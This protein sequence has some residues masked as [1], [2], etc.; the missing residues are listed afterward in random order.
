M[1]Y[2]YIKL[3]ENLIDSLYQLISAIVI[4][5]YQEGILTLDETSK[6]KNNIFKKYLFKNVVC[7]NVYNEK[8][9]GIYNCFTTKFYKY[10]LELIGEFKNPSLFINHVD[11]F[12][13]TLDI[14]GYE[15]E[16]NL[17][18]QQINDYKTSICNK[19]IYS[20]NLYSN[21]Y[22]N[23]VEHRGGWK[24]VITN[25]FDNK[26]LTINDSN[27]YLID[28]VENYINNNDLVIK[29][30]WFGIIHSTQ[31]TPNFLGIT[32]I[33]NIIGSSH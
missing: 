5:E 14:N 29:K 24:D 20:L 10:D 27:Y 33:S 8:I 2:I 31:Y 1:K 28:I 22:V 32:N 19:N 6:F 7:R 12:I 4:S 18:L 9:Q 13:K 15:D 23:S 21:K 11:E 3:S 26:I 17:W 25:L 30:E 16:I